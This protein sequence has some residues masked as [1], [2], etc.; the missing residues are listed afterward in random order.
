MDTML[1]MNFLFCMIILVFGITKYSQTS[2]KAFLYIG[3][4]YGWFAICNIQQIMGWG[5]G[6]MQM[7]LAIERIF[8]Y[9]LI[10]IGLLI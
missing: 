7:V 1:L 5:S 3:L 4:A 8:G 9:A 6:S 2:R 10:Y